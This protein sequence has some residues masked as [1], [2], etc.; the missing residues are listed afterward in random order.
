MYVNILIDHSCYKNI[1]GAVDSLSKKNASI[2]FRKKS[3][4]LIVPAYNLNT[5]V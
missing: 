4:G 5:S 3:A 1:Y 2:D